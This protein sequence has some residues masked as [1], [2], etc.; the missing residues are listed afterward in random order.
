MQTAYGN[1]CCA[2]SSWVTEFMLFAYGTSDCHERTAIT[3]IFS[4]DGLSYYQNNGCA[5]SEL[6]LGDNAV[7]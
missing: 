6:L 2:H 5:V 4:C 3:V 1:D 7:L